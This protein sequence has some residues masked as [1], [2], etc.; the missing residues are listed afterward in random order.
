MRNETPGNEVVQP[1]SRCPHCGGRQLTTTS[2]NVDR[3]SYWRC[4]SCGEVWN[5]SRH[6]PNAR[7]GY[8]HR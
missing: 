3:S 6:E 4:L 5:M 1:P 8:R 7:A 2:K